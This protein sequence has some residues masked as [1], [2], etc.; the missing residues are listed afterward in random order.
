MGISSSS[1]HG[2]CR[3]LVQDLASGGAQLPTYLQTF[4]IL[5]LTK[6]GNERSSFKH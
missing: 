4:T 1:N 3:K 6:P 5:R 2:K